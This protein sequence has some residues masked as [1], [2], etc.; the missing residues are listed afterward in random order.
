[1]S[2]IFLT[3]VNNDNSIIL[4]EKKQFKT[5]NFFSNKIEIFVFSNRTTIADDSLL[6]DISFFFK[7]FDK[8]YNVIPV[9]FTKL[10]LF[11]IQIL[12]IFSSYITNT[13][14]SV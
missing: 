13:L 11:E 7:D 9:F 5:I 2:D 6:I 4:T 12:G 1:L 14:S 10:F 8:F 3:V